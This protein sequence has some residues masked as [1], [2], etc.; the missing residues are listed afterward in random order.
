MKTLRLV[1]VITGA[2]LLEINLGVCKFLGDFFGLI[3]W[4]NFFFFQ[5][6]STCVFSLGWN[7]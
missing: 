4:I 6:I 2:T 1:D 3:F 7:S 5:V